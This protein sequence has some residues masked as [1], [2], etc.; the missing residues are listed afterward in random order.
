MLS[1]YITQYKGIKDIEDNI[2]FY[3][4]KFKEDSVLCFRDANVNKADQLKIFTIFGNFFGW[5]PN[6][7]DLQD[8]DIADLFEKTGYSQENHARFWDE[9]HLDMHDT[10]IIAWHIEHFWR[11]RRTVAS[12]WN[13]ITFD[14]SEES[15]KT[16]F[17]DTNSAWNMINKEDQEFLKKCKTL[18]YQSDEIYEADVVVKHWKFD[19]YLLQFDF[20]IGNGEK[21]LSSFDGREPSIQE[22]E[23]FNRIIM[24]AKVEIKNNL[25]IRIVH[26]W[27]QGDLLI[28]D[29]F[30]LAHTVTGGFRPEERYFETIWGTKTIN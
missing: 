13:M 30:K 18:T 24:F 8:K 25:D 27:K 15:G 3:Y 10:A 12:I 22:I 2:E 6:E 26:K 29:L 14:C 17:V 16:Y 7:K 23:N 9:D 20:S 5:L 19:Q 21:Y 28:P 1:P 4:N 11:K